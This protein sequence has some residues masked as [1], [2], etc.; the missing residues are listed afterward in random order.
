[1]QDRRHRQATACVLA[2]ALFLAGCGTEQAE[3][4]QEAVSEVAVIPEDPSPA[5]TGLTSAVPTEPAGGESLAGE[6]VSCDP[7]STELEPAATVQVEIRDGAISVDTDRVSA[8][9]IRFEVTNAGDEPHELIVVRADGPDALPPGST[10]GVDESAIEEGTRYGEVGTFPAGE[11]CPGVF[12][13]IPG[14]YVLFCNVVEPDAGPNAGHFERG[15][16]V[17]ITAT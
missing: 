13:L 2:V 8:G 15:E 6:A 12:D 14:D 9:T 7:T 3:Q 11:T 1:V 16:W 4:T 10:G 17:E 5:P